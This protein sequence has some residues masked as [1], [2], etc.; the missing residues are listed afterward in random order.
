MKRQAKEIKM[1]KLY[2]VSESGEWEPAEN[3]VCTRGQER[4]SNHTRSRCVTCV[5][6]CRFRGMHIEGKTLSSTRKHEKISPTL[7]RADGPRSAA[8]PHALVWLKAIKARTLSLHNNQLKSVS[9]T[10]TTKKTFTKTLLC[11]GLWGRTDRAVTRNSCS[12]RYDPLSSS[13]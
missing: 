4:D 7:S 6:T 12:R 8:W 1:R 10:V 11:V 9:S 5:G 3:L 13:P 2:G